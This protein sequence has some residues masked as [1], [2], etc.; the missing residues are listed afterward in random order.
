MLGRGQMRHCRFEGVHR[1]THD[2]LLALDYVHERRQH[3]GLD[4]LELGLEVQ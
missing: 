2:E 3:V 1:L 4:G